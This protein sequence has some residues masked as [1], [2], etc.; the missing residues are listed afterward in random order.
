MPVDAEEHGALSD[1]AHAL[2]DPLQGIVGYLE[3][4]EIGRYGEVDGEL[5]AVVHRIA[6]HARRLADRLDLAMALMP[7]A[8]EAAGRP[9]PE[10]T[11]PAHPAEEAVRRAAERAGERGIE[12]ESLVAE[13]LPLVPGGADRLVALLLSLLRIALLEE[14]VRH[15]RL[16]GDPAA[17][18]GVRF[19]VDSAPVAGSIA[20]PGR[21][22]SLPPEDGTLER[23]VLHLLAP[24]LGGRVEWPDPSCASAGPVLHLPSVEAG[25]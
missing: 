5:M 10:A 11:R 12:V 19:H 7:L 16:R 3:L 6:A 24:G 2:K 25:P 9:S 15:L 1:L 8:C 20:S 14:G 23:T 4:V 17:D 18:G 22:P 13:G 21:S